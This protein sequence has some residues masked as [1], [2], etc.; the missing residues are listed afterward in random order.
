MK[1]KDLIQF[2]QI[3]SVV[4]LLDAD[5]PDEAKK[6]ISTFVISD[7][8][9]ERIAKLMV[10]QLGFDEAV[11]HKGVLIVGNYGTGKSH[12]MSV[13]SLVAE[14]ATYA[15]MIRHPKVVDAVASIAGQ[16]K[17]LRIEVGGLEMPLRQIITQQIERFLKKLGV[18][19]TFPAADQELN[20][21]DSFE[22]MMAAFGEKF[23]NQ[24]LLLVVD[25]FLEYLQSRRDHELVLDLA[26]LRQIGEVAKHLKFRFVAGVQEAI[27][28]SGRFQHVADSIRRVNERFTQILIDRQ[29]VSF[30]VSAR[31][32]KKSAD[33]QNKIREYL[34]PFAKFYGSMNERMDEYV[35]LF[36]VHPDY[37]KTFEQ[38]H[39]TEKRGAL[40]TIEAAMQAILDLDVPT[41]RPQLIAYESFWNTVKSNQ[42]L[43]ADP[44]IKEVLRVSEVLESRIQQA[45]TRPAYKPM[46]LRVING[47]AVHRLTTGG[48]IH[49]PIGP[50]A[51]ELRDSLC[52]F[53]SGVEDMPG[54]PAEN[55]LSMVQTVMRE[56]LKTVNGQ[57]ISKAADSEQYYLDLKKDIDYDAQIEKRAE[58]LSD[59]A[60][61]RAYYD[62]LWQLISEDPNK[63]SYVSGFK[64]WEYQIEWQEHRVERLGYLFFGAPNDRP[65]AQPERDFYIYFTQP[66]DKPRF[67]DSQLSDEVFFRLKSPDEDYKRHLSQYAASLDLASTASGGAKAVYQSKGQDSLRAMSKWLQEKQLTAF[68][69]TYQGKA[70]TLQDWA[71][72][73]SLRDRARLGP[74]EKINFRDIVNI[75]SG[76][77]LAQRFSDIA[78]EYPK[79][80]VLVTEA[81][82]KSLITGTL[83]A[84]AG[85]T[86]TKDATAVLDALEVLDGERIDPAGSRYAQEVLNRLRA[87]GHGQ[88]LNRNE[89]VTG[90]TDVEYFAPARLRLEPDLLAVVLGT[91]VYSGDIVLSITGDKIDSGKLALLAERSLDE[92]KQFKH[93][94]APK[95]INLAVL[96]ALF[97]LLGL[98]SGLAQKASQGDTEP[99]VALQEKVSALVPRVLKAGSDLQHGKLGFWGQNLLRDEETKDWYAR[100]DALKKFTES[101]SPYNTVGKLKNLRVTQEDIDAQKKNLDVL[102]GVERLLELV[103]EL[104]TTASYLSQAEMVLQPGHDWVKQAEA[105]RKAL[106]DKLGEDRT[107]ERAATVLSEGRQTLSKLKKD[108]IA[109]YIASHSK[110]RLGVSEEKTRNALRRDDRLL[111][112]RV[113]AGVSLMPTSQL[114]G[115]EDALNGLKSCSA[116]DEPTLLTAPVCPHCQF[117]PSAEQLELLP[118]A[119]RLS[120]LDDDLDQ[121]QANWQQT[122]L[123][124]LEDPFTQDSLGLLPSSS[125]KLI[126][127]F[128]AARKLPEPVTADFANAVQEALSGLEKITVKTDE[129]RQALLQGGSPATPEELRKRFD[130]LISERGKGKDATK[131]RFVIE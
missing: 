111:S 26:I 81:N 98:P 17:V 128:L 1:Y 72:G 3:E 42:V 69:V 105:A 125:K 79:F 68:E 113:L 100:L 22:E 124:N 13:L 40:K 2:E 116:L 47:L 127:A 131:L 76:L 114:T 23:P 50:T 14:D 60:L 44:N 31:L 56:V 101:L 87:K 16:F 36:P 24:G 122:L 29:D 84:L 52:L 5:R 11:D 92:L 66:F 4:Q 55:L 95:E 71:K 99:V 126:D 96:R 33:Q 94:E 106:F 107:A 61:D 7:D 70:K 64:I 57:F 39:F 88:V 115:F 18:D 97:E 25:E 63:P 38:I 54:E 58:A 21:K 51:A 104:G 83:R 67:T 45:F 80:P 75:V 78:P 103:G 62:A 27:F 9:A 86:R 77:V 117:R 49:I 112:L 37:L 109:A 10:P 65:T 73:V 43:R 91:L 53:Q 15:P 6:L 30:V 20:N 28:D 89:L 8:M 120:K 32:L 74:E 102:T 85:G 110:A 46:A 59:D 123:E 129:L 34:K 35:R 48:D 108:Y 41:D 90:A 118:A 12:L 19:F 119:N 93:I 82:R 121:L 130:A